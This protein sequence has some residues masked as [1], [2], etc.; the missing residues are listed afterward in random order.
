MLVYYYLNVIGVCVWPWEKEILDFVSGSAA[1]A[2]I[3][4]YDIA[5]H[6]LCV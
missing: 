5:A 3:A 6:N 4:G 2:E 1:M